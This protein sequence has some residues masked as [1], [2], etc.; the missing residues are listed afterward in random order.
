[1]C[2]N[3]SCID[4][5]MSKG[6]PTLNGDSKIPTTN[7]EEFFEK[8]MFNCKNGGVETKQQFK[9][10]LQQRHSFEG[11]TVCHMQARN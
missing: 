5:G 1:M 9:D 7:L 6:S 3:L 4:S 2:P 8:I 11:V 10:K